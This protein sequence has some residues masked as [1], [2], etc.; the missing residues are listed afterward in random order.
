MTN[1]N[2]EVNESGLRILKEIIEGNSLPEE[3]DRY[4]FDNKDDLVKHINCKIALVLYGGATKFIRRDDPDLNLYS[5]ADM[6]AFMKQYRYIFRSEKGKN[7]R[8]QDAFEIWL[9]SADRLSFDGIAFQP[10]RTKENPK[11][12]NVFTGFAVAPAKGGSYALFKEHVEQN[13]CA[14]D[15]KLATFIWD[16]SADL[17]QNPGRKSGVA[18]VLR[19]EKG[20]GKSTFSNVLAHLIGDRYTEVIDSAEGFV[21][22]FS[23]HLER[24]LL[25][26]VEE[27]YHANNPAHEARLKSLVTGHRL[28]IERKGVDTYTAPSF[29]RVVMTSNADHVLPSSVG[30]RRF[31]C[32]DVSAARK[33]DGAF[34]QEMHRE[35]DAGGYQA[36]MADLQSRDISKRDF[37]KPPITAALSD[38][39][40][41]SMKPE[42]AW[43]ASLLR[44]G[45]IPLPRPPEGVDCE[46]EWLLDEPFTIER[47]HLFASFQQNAISY[48]GPQSPEALGRLLK[49]VYPAVGMKKATLPGRGRVNCYTFPSRRDTLAAFLATRPGLILEAEEF[50]LEPYA[51]AGAIQ[52]ALSIIDLHQHRMSA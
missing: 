48:R 21:G 38:Q 11:S 15:L 26:V 39:I 31:V 27:A 50:A 4:T 51:S 30:E 29:F 32:L 52:P 9:A 8:E 22:R 41:L 46:L 34:F 36:L 33:Q 23:G 2:S 5:R 40:R 47:N 19:G 18:I 3:S 35:L 20:T 49:K 10:D 7:D 14:G 17:L 45:M 12:L 1:E 43:W 13:V 6:S 37:S 24:K 28:S 25:L 42:E 16:W 44:T